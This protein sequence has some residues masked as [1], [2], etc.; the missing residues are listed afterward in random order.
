MEHFTNTTGAKVPLAYL[1]YIQ[2][3]TEQNVPDEKIIDIAKKG[4]ENT[5][6]PSRVSGNNHRK[7]KAQ[8]L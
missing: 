7:V 4:L 8:L 5:E 2:V 3:L 6:A 1:D